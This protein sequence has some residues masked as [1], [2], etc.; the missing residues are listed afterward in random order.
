MRSQIQPCMQPCRVST[1][2]SCN[3][4]FAYLCVRA[5]QPSPHGTVRT[6]FTELRARREQNSR[7]ESPLCYEFLT[8]GN[9]V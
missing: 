6:F 7:N 2:L 5:A 8:R 9:R 1:A 3:F 4:C